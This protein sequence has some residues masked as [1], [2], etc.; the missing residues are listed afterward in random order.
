M[1][2][3]EVRELL[4]PNPLLYSNLKKYI[5][6][7]DC[8]EVHKN[9]QILFDYFM[10]R[11]I[12]IDGFVTDT[13]SLSGLQMYHKTIYEFNVAEEENTVVFWDSYFTELNISAPVN[14]CS[15]RVINPEL[16]T[17]NVVIWGSGIAGGQAYDALTSAGVDVKYFV[18][19]NKALAGGKKFGIPILAPD[20][21][22]KLE[23]KITIVEAM[24]RWKDVE[25]NIQDKYR[26]RF[27]YTLRNREGCEFEEKGIFNLKNYWLFHYFQSNKVYIYGFGVH[28]KEMARFLGLLDFNF[29]GFLTDEDEPIT[30]EIKQQYPFKCVEDI[31]YEEDYYIWVYDIKRIVRLQELGFTYFKQYMY[32]RYAWDI[33]IDRKNLLDIN[34]A[35]NYRSHGKY[36]GIKVH[37]S[38]AEDVY[39]IAV[40]GNSTTDGNL[41]PFKSWPELLFEELEDI[42]VYNCGVCGYTSAQEVIKL[43]RDVLRLKPD[44]IIVYDGTGDL[45]VNDKYPFTSAYVEMVYRYAA[46]H[47]DDPTDYI[48]GDEAEICRGIASEGSRFDNWLSNIQTMHAIASDRNIKFFSFCSPTLGSKRGRTIH[49]KNM[50]L[51]AISSGISRHMEEAFRKRIEQMQNLPDYMY[52]LSHIFDGKSN[53]YMDESHVWEEGNK[54]IA[55]EIK[56]IILPVLKE[57]AYKKKTEL[58]PEK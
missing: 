44:M 1:S 55:E 19:S 8:A 30:D 5:W 33:S 48:K 28:E 4:V 35:H 24:V 2:G 14:T 6:I 21:L 57:S 9:A 39:K 47:I 53:I 43:I 52:D 16:D 31:L 38:E 58:G 51:S 22:G 46:A 56:K 13:K 25:E 23:N 42:T 32:Q 18:D 27:Y 34:L 15:A 40:L 12:Y 54:I 50:L 36:P 29:L 45:N 17:S 37:G 41:Y 26:D 49:E 10:K 7:S 11:N 20:E 3:N